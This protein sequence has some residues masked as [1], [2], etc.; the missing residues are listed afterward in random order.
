MRKI[1]TQIYDEASEWVVRHRLDDLDAEARRR[2]DAWLRLSPLHVRA[3]L[4]MSS[5]WEGVPALD[6]ALN[7]S[8][9]ELIA[10]ARAQNNV[11]VPLGEPT[12]GVGAPLSPSQSGEIRRRG[13]CG[14]FLSL[15]AAL[16]MVVGVA[17]WLYLQRGVYSTGIGEQRTVTL[18]DGSVVELNARS[19]IEVHYTDR[20]RSVDLLEGQALF[21]VAKDPGKPF[22]VESDRTQVRA[23]GTQFDVYRKNAGT[24]VTVVEGRVAVRTAERGA[25]VHENA[26]LAAADKAEPESAVVPRPGNT[27][28]RRAGQ[29]DEPTPDGRGARAPDA[30]PNEVLVGAG[31]QLLVAQAVPTV[32]KPADVEAATA[33]TQQQLI[34]EYAPLTEVA[35]EFNRYNRRP[36]VIEDSSLKEFHISGSFSST[37]PTL[38]LRFLREQPGIA[39][40]E[41]ASDI[42][43]SRRNAGA[44]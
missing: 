13:H 10:R 3:Y 34:F 9:D 31:Q 5:I 19:R 20:S 1:N 26:D 36:L 42:R 25:A 35:E 24:L 44:G 23:V 14:R 28:A 27:S 2:F 17:G 37:D 33:W 21:R 11:V 40:H 16:L 32:P 6:H 8:A 12:S 29:A 41:T 39:V 22:I 15:A 38:L 18:V 30:A 43:I 4:E 7:P